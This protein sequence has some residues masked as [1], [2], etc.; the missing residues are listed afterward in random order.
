MT[1]REFQ[2]QI[3]KMYLSYKSNYEKS[4]RPAIY[5]KW[6]IGGIGGGSCWDSSRASHHAIDAEPEPEFSAL[7]SILEKFKPDISYFEYKKLL[8][9]VLKTREY[10]YN[11]YYGNCTNTMEKYI[12]LDD[13][14][15]YIYQ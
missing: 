11:E 4:G 2:D 5:V 1:F 9:K 13:L 6:T 3:E 12:Y 8:S 10:S 7:D 14:F 15:N